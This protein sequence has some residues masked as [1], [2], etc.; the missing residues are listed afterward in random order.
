MFWCGY[1]PFLEGVK[2]FI[3]SAMKQLGSRARGVRAYLAP[4]NMC[5]FHQVIIDNVGKVICRKSVRLDKNE[6]FF[7]V[8]FPKA[9][10]NRVLEHGPSKEIGSEAYDVGLAA[11]STIIRLRVIN[12]AAGPGISGRLSSIMLLA[13]HR[14]ELMGVAEAAISVAMAEE[15]LGM[16]LID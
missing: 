9:S 14:F 11:S 10:I 3:A 5:D 12:G 4:N 6:I 8:L 15:L 13:P 7:R 16:V 2:R 1:E